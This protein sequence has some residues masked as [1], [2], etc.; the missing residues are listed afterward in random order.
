MA[1][2]EIFNYNKSVLDFYIVNYFP[3]HF[4]LEKAPFGGYVIDF[5]DPFLKVFVNEFMQKEAV[6]KSIETFLQEV[7]KYLK[8]QN[9]LVSCL[10][11]L[12][13]LSDINPKF[14]AYLWQ[15]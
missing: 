11:Y 10:N 8:N 6:G 1:S 14:Q 5:S 2:L 12:Y 4:V 7:N 13:S 3:L 15:P 9:Q